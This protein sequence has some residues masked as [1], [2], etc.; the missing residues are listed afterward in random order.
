M[1]LVLSFVK[2]EEVRDH[3]IE[4]VVDVLADFGGMKALYRLDAAIDIMEGDRNGR[5]L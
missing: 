5:F 4:S 1:A 3:L 2:P